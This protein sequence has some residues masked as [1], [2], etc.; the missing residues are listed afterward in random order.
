MPVI[1]QKYLSKKISPVIENE[2]VE[3]YKKAEKRVLF[4]DYDGT[5]VNYQKSPRKAKPDEELYHILD[6]LSKND[7]TTVVLITGRGKETFDQWFSTKDYTLIVEHGVWIK[8]PAKNWVNLQNGSLKDEW[9]DIVLPIVQFYTDRT[10]ASLIEE[11]THS[12]S[13]HYRNTD[14]DLGISV[15]LS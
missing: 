4:L 8:E 3:Q 15:L 6:T 5:L 11:K 9:K 2:I 1:Q 13:W 10:P 7:N 12:I 14:P